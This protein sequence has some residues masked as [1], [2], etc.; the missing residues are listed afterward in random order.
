MNIFQ[1]LQE[2]VAQKEIEGTIET[3]KQLRL[4][5]SGY[6]EAVCDLQNTEYYFL[7][8]D[9]ESKAIKEWVDSYYVKNF[10]FTFG[11]WEG[12]P[13]Q[14]GYIIVKAKDIKEAGRKFAKWFPNPEDEETLNCSDYYGAEEWQEIL[15]KGY[16]K[17]QEPLAIMQ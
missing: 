13:F 11:S 14:N 9:A 8:T 12:M 5:V 2:R 15:E 17:E 1:K 10:Y 6:L 16:Y 7:L 3:P 4:F